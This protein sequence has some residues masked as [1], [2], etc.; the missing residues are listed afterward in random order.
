MA[1][2]AQ[3]RQP[4]RRAPQ[5]TSH[6]ELWRLA[7]AQLQTALQPKTYDAWFAQTRAV[8]MRA[9]KLVISVD[10]VYKRETL[11]S[12]Y[13]PLISRAVEE[14]AGRRIAVEVVVDAAPVPDEPPEATLDARGQAP[15]KPA[16][17]ARE[18][19]AGA[20]MRP[21]LKAAYTMDNFVVGPS[22]QIAHAAAA[23][24][25]ENP[26]RSHNPLFIYAESGFGKT[27]LLQAIAHITRAEYRTQYVSLRKY[28]D[29]FTNAARSG[30]RSAF[31]DFRAKYEQADV[32]I[33][34]DIQD[35][36]RTDRTQD[37]FFDLFN[38]MHMEDRQIVL[39]C[40]TSPRQLRQLPDRLV[41]RFEWGLVV[42]INRPDLE[43]RLA[44]LRQK[45]R[46]RGLVAEDDVLRLIAQRASHNVRELEGVLGHVELRARMAGSPITLD[47]ALRAMEDYSFDEVKRSPPSVPEIINATCEVTGVSAE[48]FTTKRKDQRAARS[49]HLAMYLAREHTGLSYKEIGSYF[50]D[51]DHTTVLHGY[52]KILKELEGDPRKGLPPKAETQRAISDIR[53]RLRL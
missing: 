28:V 52:R 16:E 31:A 42:E 38:H 37:Q 24:V 41:T 35:L 14:V 50:G 32:L 40:D 47:L 8:E 45:C 7:L 46:E 49:R 22:N 21:A 30:S 51:R 44:I 11:L 3:G 9:G 26:G 13:Y 43:L 2:S 12:N 48:A 4:E 5:I 29:D 23:A 19:P 18:A 36:R 1:A 33:I 34:D 53:A 15:P 39:S 10:N 27:H 25:A 6:T 20:F 17:P